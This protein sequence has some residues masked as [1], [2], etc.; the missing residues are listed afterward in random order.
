MGG[1]PR[2]IPTTG[3]Y[4]WAR[5]DIGSTTAYVAH[6]YMNC[7]FTNDSIILIHIVNVQLAAYT[8]QHLSNA[9][10][11]YRTVKRLGIPDSNIILMLADDASC[12]TRNKFP[13]VS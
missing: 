6:F 10:G 5:R 7:G 11:M 13:G 2:S 12:N 3:R 8:Y 1:Q 4:L 9:L